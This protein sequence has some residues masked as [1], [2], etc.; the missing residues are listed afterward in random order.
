MNVID[1]V[2]N[3][4][5]STI[6]TAPD[7]ADTG[8]SFVV[9]TDE[10]ALFPDPAEDGEYNL[11]IYPPDTQIVRANS[12]MVRVTGRTTD[13]FTVTRDVEDS[14][15]REVV[16][17]DKVA[18]VISAKMFTD[19]DSALGTIPTDVADLTDTTGVIPS[20]VS[21]L[22]DITDL[23]KEDV[24]ELADTTGLISGKLDKATNVT[25]IDDTGIADGEIAVFNLTDTKLETSNVTIATTVGADDTTVPTS[26]AVE[27]LV[28]SKL[29]TW[30]GSWTTATSYALYDAVENDGSSYVCIDAHTSGDEDDE[31]GVGADWT[32]YW[33]LFVEG[34]GGV[35][36]QTDCSGGTSDTYGVLS[37][38]VNS[39]N[40]VYTVSLGSYVS[41]S[42][43]VYL[44]GQLQTQGTSEDWVETTPASGTFTFATAPAT[45][46]IIIAVYQFTTGSTGNA[47]TLDGLHGAS[48]ATITGIETLTNKTLTNPTINFT[49]KAV[50]QGVLVKA[51]LGSQQA[52]ITD[53]TTT[54]ISLD[55]EVFDIGS[56]FNTGT[57]RFTAP[58]N[59]YYLVSGMITFENTI[60]DKTYQAS[61]REGGSTVVCTSA[62]T[63]AVNVALS[64]TLP[65]TILY[66]EATN[67]LELTTYLSVGANTVDIKEGERYTF[68]NIILLSI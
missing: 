40:T 20:D 56:D 53:L 41:G 26:L 19:I 32:T 51:Y 24:S 39:S 1:P 16:V 31:P 49:D 52:N 2:S 15:S 65:A 3:L 67:Y 22:T 8:T 12:T 25:S 38:L 30:Q 58:V 18:M 5:V 42:L 4:L 47:D 9:T 35:S 44:N 27:T 34:I 60:T 28:N 36:I 6:A 17:G 7:P 50:T 45:G 54:V 29:F 48:Y 21:D 43:R 11:I 63:S 13:T 10:G 57:Y 66:L 23:I 64:A 55:T 37:G 62:V 14:N 61:I 46:D 33:D 68:L 59:G